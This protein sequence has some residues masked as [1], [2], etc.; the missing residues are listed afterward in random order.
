MHTA[1]TSSQTPPATT[2]QVAPPRRARRAY[3]ILAII[4]AVGVM[5]QAFLAG[6][7]IFLAG[8]WMLWHEGIGH[9]LTSPIPII[10][11]ITLILS[12]TGRLSSADRW[13]SAGL[14]VLALVQPVVLYL[15]GL[16]PWLSALHPLNALLLFALP[17]LMSYRVWRLIREK[18]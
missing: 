9:L 5:A 11:L 14:F 15:R 13:M 10:P 17:L 6:A 3:L 8:D 16:V 12:F 4:F 18:E 2:Q 1:H 7:G